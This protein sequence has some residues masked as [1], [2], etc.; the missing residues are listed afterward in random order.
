[1]LLSYHRYSN[2]FI[3]FSEGF[4]RK[5]S[6]NQKDYIM[7]NYQTSMKSNHSKK[8]IFILWSVLL[9]LLCIF[10]IKFYLEYQQIKDAIS[11]PS[12]TIGTG[13]I[14][15]IASFLI[16]TVPLFVIIKL[17]DNNIN[18]WFILEKLSDYIFMIIEI[19]LTLF[20]GIILWNSKIDQS[21]SIIDAVLHHSYYFIFGF[22]AF[23]LLEIVRKYVDMFIK[24]KSFSK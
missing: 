15:I 2:S 24:N 22:S 10:G 7:I 19:I 23:I 9:V 21:A 14:K 8:R 1:M 16:I 11:L 18:K 3:D 13:Y 6:Q 20:V 5:G 17:L 12:I 4:R